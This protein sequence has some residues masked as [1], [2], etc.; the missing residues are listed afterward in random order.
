MRANIA[1]ILRAVDLGSG[2][3]MASMISDKRSVVLVQT[4]L[5]KLVEGVELDKSTP[6]E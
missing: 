4:F 6:R 5:D 1:R 2:V 3:A